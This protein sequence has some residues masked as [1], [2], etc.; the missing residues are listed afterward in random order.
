MTSVSS[1]TPR[2]EASLLQVDGLYVHYGSALALADVSL[3]IAEGE[4]VAVLG[5]N[6]MGKTTLLSALI[7]L[8]PASNGT[9]RFRQRDITS[10]PTQEIVAAGMAI[11]PQGRRVFAS[12][13]VAEHLKIVTRPSNV[14]GVGFGEDDVLSLFPRLG[15]RRKL[16]ASNLSGGEQQMLAIGRALMTNPTLLLLDEP[17]E[18]LAPILISDLS[19]KLAQLRSAGLSMLLAE[20]RVSFALA[21]ADRVLGVRERGAFFFDGSP[22]DYAV[23]AKR[24]KATKV[25]SPNGNNRE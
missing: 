2:G 13:T 1:P 23:A 22:A 11:V 12:L 10:L 7:G 14:G 21:L 15:E 8:L 17:T 3:R 24:R 5:R 18:G 19:D 16:L 9:I 20:Q 6:G 25:R 4:C